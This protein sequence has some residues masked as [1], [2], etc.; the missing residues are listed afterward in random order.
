MA[1]FRVVYETLSGETKITYINNVATMEEAEE[2]ILCSNPD[3]MQV[4]D[5]RVC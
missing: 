3:A 5:V 4:L 1:K 2:S